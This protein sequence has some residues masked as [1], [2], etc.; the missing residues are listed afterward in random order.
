MLYRYIIS[1]TE[2]EMKNEGI[3]ITLAG[4]RLNCE[5][6]I[7]VNMEDSRPD[8]KAKFKD[9]LV[10]VDELNKETVALPALGMNFSQ[11][12]ITLPA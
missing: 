6:I 1:L 5:Y 4:G 11:E 2:K 7:H 12:T 10:K 9:V 3:T 8:L